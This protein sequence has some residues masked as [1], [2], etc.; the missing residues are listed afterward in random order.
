MKIAVRGSEEQYTELSK[1]VSDNHELFH[2][3]NNETGEFD[4]L[5]DL[6]FDSDPERIVEYGSFANKTFVLSSAKVQLE[7]VLAEYAI[8]FDSQLIGMN[9]IPTFI[10]RDLAEICYG[11]QVSNEAFFV[12]LGWKAKTV[13][14]RV[15]LVT[16]RI[17][18]MIV[19]EAYYTVQEGTAS[20]EDIDLGMKLGT[21]YPK[22]PFQWCEDVGI[23]HVYETLEA[24]Y[25]DT[26][27][28]RYKICPML[29]TE[30]LRSLQ[31][32]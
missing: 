4:A 24:M 27:D 28:E 29:R 11:D 17:I 13:E 15:G 16:P 7:A 6:E 3:K 14:S 19:N 20:K 25:F 5:F 12:N 18:F 21:A 2:V 10:D 31:V 32:G 8:A 26:G 9:A 23:D 30:Y 22:G 1:R